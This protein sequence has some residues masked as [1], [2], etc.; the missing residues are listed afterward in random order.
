MPALG[1]PL[2]CSAPA[3]VLGLGCGSGVLGG[4]R[5]GFAARCWALAA[6]HGLPG[7]SCAQGRGGWQDPAGG[8]ATAGDTKVFQVTL[9]N[10]GHGLWLCPK[11]G[12]QSRWRCGFSEQDVCLS[13][14]LSPNTAVPHAT[15]SHQRDAP[16]IVK[17]PC[18]NPHAVCHEGKL[19]QEDRRYF[20]QYTRPGEVRATK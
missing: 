18:T 15:S 9:V 11:G 16:R 6:L 5:M 14:R 10:L 17:A 3:A 8:G 20:S 4:L 2:L 7:G 1:L 12:C 13:P 19:F